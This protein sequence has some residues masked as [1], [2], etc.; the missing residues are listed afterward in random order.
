MKKYFLVDPVRYELL[1]NN[2]N[3][4]NVT[5]N[6]NELFS[7][8]NVKKTKEIDKEMDQILNDNHLSDYEKNEQFNNK[9][10]GFVSNFHAAVMTP[11]SDAI[12]GKPSSD[13]NIDALPSPS[14]SLYSLEETL[15]TIPSSYQQ[16][17]KK[18]VNFL[19]G[20]EAFAWNENGELKYKGKILQGSDVNKLLNDAVRNKKISSGNSTFEAFLGALKNEGYPV[21]KLSSAKKK[22]SP[23]F[24]VEKPKKKIRK[25]DYNTLTSI[26]KSW[27]KSK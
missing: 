17:A 1:L 18:L 19:K 20:N 6:S 23:S 13:D 12:L 21:H 14:T 24:R 4:Q 11:K 7:H 25:A 22:K 15:N 2:F 3:A 10:N 9:L 26:L 27:V 16:N 8:P 5:S